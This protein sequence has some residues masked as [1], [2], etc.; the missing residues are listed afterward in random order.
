MT[1]FGFLLVSCVLLA[2]GGG[3]P[4]AEPTPRPDDP[5]LTHSFSMPRGKSALATADLGTQPPALADTLMAE[6]KVAAVAHRSAQHCAQEGALEGSMGLAIRFELRD[7]KAVAFEADPR[8]TAGSC[9]EQALARELA[10]VSGLPAGR[11]L[12]RLSF[13]PSS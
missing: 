12:L 4:P 10:D 11:A 8:S 2:C 3:A 13:H 9:L 7:G 6:A 1:R 5:E